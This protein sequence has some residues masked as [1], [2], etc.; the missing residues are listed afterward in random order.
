MIG[1]SLFESGAPFMA[2]NWTISIITLVA[3]I[4]FSQVFSRKSRFFLLFPVI[5][6]IAVG[7]ICAVIGTQAG[8]I[9]AGNPANLTSAFHN[10]AAAPWFTIRPLIP[11]KWGFP[12]NTSLLIAGSFGMLAAYLASMVESIGDYHS[13]AKISEAP[14]PTERMISKGIGS[15]GLGCLVAGILQSGSGTTS[16]SENIGA[17][18]IT[19]VAS[20]RV[21]RC[22]AIIMLVIP[23]FGKAGAFFASLPGPVVGAM[24]VGLFG[25][26]AAVGLSNLQ[27]VNLN[28]S[29]N[30]FVLGISLF[31]GLSVRF[32]FQ[33]NPISW[34]AIGT[35]G[36]T[37][38]MILQTIL[39]TAMAVS[40]LVAIILDNSLPGATRKERGLT[41]WEKEATEE[42]WAKAEAEWTQ[43]KEGEERK[44]AGF[45]AS[46]K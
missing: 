40:A 1:L 27:Y 22:G 26:I 46:Q 18:G 9:P 33:S 35:V 3:L 10:I 21:I 7:W 43:M 42:S 41:Y 29:R 11:F 2:G 24:Y 44:L 8:W 25:L 4:V 20:R 36:G 38:G 30:L 12:T 34:G 6:A 13:C 19:R 39:T 28:N 14:P 5:S 31:S 45:E 32:A 17:M 37:L 16:Y 15:E 23:I